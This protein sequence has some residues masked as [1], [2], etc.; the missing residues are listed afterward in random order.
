MLSDAMYS[1]SRENLTVLVK[2]NVFSIT[3]LTM[4]AGRIISDFNLLFCIIS[5]VS[6]LSLS[7]ECKLFVKSLPVV[8]QS[9]ATLIGQE[10]LCIADMA[11]KS[12]GMSKHS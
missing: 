6:S 9:D 3:N 2:P 7:K 5:W 12:I 11:K 4:F 1:I 10:F 8:M